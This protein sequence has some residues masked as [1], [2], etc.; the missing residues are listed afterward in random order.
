MAEEKKEIWNHILING[1]F[2]Q[3]QVKN[4]EFSKEATLI[5]IEDLKPF[6]AKDEQGN[7]KIPTAQDANNLKRDIYSNFF[8]KPFKN[9]LILSGAG[10]SIGIGEGDKV[11]L[12]MSQLWQKARDKYLIKDGE[13]IKEDGFKLICEAVEF[14][15]SKWDLEA[16]L[17]QIDGHCKFSKDKKVKLN[18]KDVPLT[19]I[20]K[21]IFDLIKNCCSLN[22]P[23]TGDFPHKQFL[24]KLLQR[25]QT[26]PRVKVFTLNY[27]LLFEY[28]AN[29]VNAIVID[30]FS[31]TMP[32]TFS[33]RYFDYDI[34]QR[35]GSKLQE[36]DNFI[37][38][39]FHLH[40]LHGS[41][42]W[43]RNDNKKVVID[44]NPDNP[45]MVYPREAK[46][47]DSYEQPYFEMMARFQR[48]LRLNNDTILVCIGYSFNDKHINA[49]IEE[50]LN[51]NPGF[52]LAVID[53]NF[54]SEKASETLKEIT[55]AAMDTDRIIMVSET[56]TD[57]A[58]HFPEIKT[59]DNIN[60]EPIIFKNEQSKD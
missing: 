44:A 13:D 5:K 40:K 28:A 11:G 35:E 9:L 23:L 36:E 48:N 20:R 45:L 27:D 16:L 41:V 12:L 46:Y 52:R 38:R 51:Q 21:Q 1:K 6:D 7:K 47:E 2:K 25:K 14:D 39:V 26:N 49:A 42:N 33:G 15:I 19:E 18:K 53:P 8:R 3:I 37:Q 55:K 54:F 32:R 60:P 24:E 59:Y 4:P 29:E 43:K 31:F 22:M 50:A 17:S 34:V 58:N 57:F 30:G 56:F 10:S